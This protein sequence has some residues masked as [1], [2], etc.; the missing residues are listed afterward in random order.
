MKMSDLPDLATPAEVAAVLRCSARFVQKQCDDRK[1]G[2]SKVAGKYLIP[3]AEVIAYVERQKVS[4]CQDQTKAPNSNS[5]TTVV[6]MKSS[7]AQAVGDAAYQRALETA[8]KL[9]KY[10]PSGS[11]KQKK[12]LPAPVIPL[13][14]VSRTS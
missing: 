11:S 12:N 1:I 5:V 9:T 4:P 8:V 7:G 2:H 6:S 13:S 14:G 10:S 3:P